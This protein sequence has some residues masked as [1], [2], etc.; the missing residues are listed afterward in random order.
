MESPRRIL[1]DDPDLPAVIDLIRRSFAYMD[2]RINPPSS[3][4]KMTLEDAR[5]HA[6]AHEIWAI[7][8]PP[9]AACFLT[10]EENRLY[11]GR[12]AVDH[13]VRRQG[14]ARKLFD[15]AEMR[16][17]AMGLPCIELGS[18]VELTENHA[19]FRALGFEKIGESSHEGFDRPTTLWFRK[20]L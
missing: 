11:L 13:T 7:G 3:L 16:A 6:L 1:P 17:R 12:L 9:V 14:L 8:A 2:A 10:I 5:A 19:T 18:R 20:T 4:G 15:L